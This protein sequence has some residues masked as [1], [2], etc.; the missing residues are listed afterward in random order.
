MTR[1]SSNRST[2]SAMF[3][4]IASGYDA[5]NRILS[6]GV[7][8]LWRRR[9]VRDVESSLAPG[10]RRRIL[11]LAAGTYDVSLALA[12][13]VP[14]STVLAVDFCL[15]MLLAGKPKLARAGNYE[16]SRITPLAG[17]GLALPLKDCSVDAI[18]VS[19][20]LRNMTPR[21][22][23]LNEAF[24]VLAPGGTV[25]ILEFGSARGRIWGGLY[26]MY[27]T[28]ILPFLG[29]RIAGDKEAYA[30]L[31][32]TISAFP[33][34]S[35]LAGELDEAGFRDVAFHKLWGGI[36]YLHTGKK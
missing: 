1:S 8:R 17:D 10:S 12:R 26:N 20:G 34:A 31:A 6:F 5:A 27:L 21:K 23:A 30:Y 4:R 29:G 15:P 35:A 11:D 13:S 22:D 32:H 24:R 7:D 2:V 3:G 9:L 18:T 33:E 36:V 28:R 19:F 14:G 25:H 16:R